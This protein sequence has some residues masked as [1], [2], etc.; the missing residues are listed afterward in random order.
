[1][2]DYEQLLESAHQNLVVL[3]NKLGDLNKL[4]Q[5][6]EE[7]LKQP[8]ILDKKFKE[9]VISNES[10]GGTVNKY[11]DDNNA[12]FT[13]KISELSTQINEFR[14]EITRLVN[15]DFTKL[16]KDLQKIFIDQTRKDLESELT[17]FDAKSKELQTKI[18]ELKKEIDRLEKIDLEKHFDKL[19][20]TLSEIFGA[21][22][23]INLTLTSIT[24]SLNIIVQTLGSI[25]ATIGTSHKETQQF[26]I[27]FSEATAKHLTEQDIE[28]KGNI[29]I[30]E[31]SIKSV[32]EQNGLLKKE[33]RTNRLIQFLG[34]GVI[35]IILIYLVLKHL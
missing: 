13:T 35:L 18:N 5:D 11:L 25:Q 9:F 14:T 31:R 32:I 30:T 20:K 29:E 21:I 3:Q 26:L 27:T 33:I 24:Q 28:A 15:T 16:F 22:N 8:E 17:K 10:L 19:Q 6:I 23:S 1:M 34:F 12:L 7:L 2:P 4:H